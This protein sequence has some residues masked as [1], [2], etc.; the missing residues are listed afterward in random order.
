MAVCRGRASLKPACSS[1]FCSATGGKAGHK[2][3]STGDGY[4]FA[5]S[6]GHSLTRPLP[7]LVQIVSDERFSE[8]LKGVRAKG[9]AIL[10]RGEDIIAQEAGEIQ[11]TGDGLSGI[12]IFDLSRYLGER[13]EEYHV[14]IDL[15]PDYSQ[16][17][18]LNMMKARKA[19]L[20]GRCA[21]ALLKGMLNEKLIPV[22]LELSEIRADSPIEE[23]EESKMLS[24]AGQLKDHR[25]GIKGTKGWIEAQV[26]AGGINSNEIYAAGLESRLVPGLFF[27]GEILDID[28]KCGG[29]NLQWAW[30]SGWTAGLHAARISTAGL[31]AAQI[32]TNGLTG[33]E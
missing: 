18:M 27:A 15:F 21:E 16:S 32:S 2:F 26:T 6:L 3:G 33:G 14:R 8:K 17:E 13:P 12:C 24:L 9:L 29:W 19:S 28:G 5:K 7:A 11:F 25:I 10:A 1:S 31:H 20:E 4:G 22:Y 30:S 23:V